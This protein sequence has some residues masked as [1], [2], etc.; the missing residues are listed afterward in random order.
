VSKVLA[1]FL[2]LWLALS[3][4]GTADEPAWLKK[5]SRVTVQASVEPVRPARGQPVSL[6]LDVTPAAGVHVYAPG[7]ASYVAPTLRLDLPEGVR[8][9]QAAAFPPGE[10]FVFGDLEELVQVYKRAFRVRQALSIDPAVARRA[11]GGLRLTGT[12]DYQACTARI[13]FPP[14]SE[15][16]ELTLPLK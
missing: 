2:P 15:P 6:V 10:P 9:R 16:F 12:L 14:Q 3:L 1:A 13:C 11:A 7:N 5:G 8:L 4:S